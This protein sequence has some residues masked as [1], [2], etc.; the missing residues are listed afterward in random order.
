MPKQKSFP[1]RL[2]AFL[3]TVATLLTVVPLGVFAT[4][5]TDL[6]TDRDIANVIILHNGAEISSLTL[7][8]NGKETLTALVTLGHYDSLAWQIRIPDT[9]EWVNISG[10]NGKTLDVTY[11]LV[12]S[13]LNASGRAHLR[14]VVK[15]DEAVFESK[16][17]EVIL[18]YNTPEGAE[19]A[20][21]AG[22]T[23]FAMR[24]LATASEGG[25]GDASDSTHELVS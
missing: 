7:A 25:T 20:L 6:E 14:H 8:E 24:R 4:E 11:A 19:S 9:E 5:T 16:P 22:S 21:N 17:V 12:G 3:L 23:V 1:K 10:K 2:I 15:S 13:M 18:S